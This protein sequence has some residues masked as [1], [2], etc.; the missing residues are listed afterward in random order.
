MKVKKLNPQYG[1]VSGRGRSENIIKHT[2]KFG[3]LFI[4][5]TLK[6]ISLFFRSS[7]RF[8]DT[9]LG[10]PNKR[11]LVKQS[12]I[13]LIWIHFLMNR[14]TSDD[15]ITLQQEGASTSSK[16]TYPSFFIYPF[17][18]YKTTITRSPMAHKTYSQEQFLVRFYRLSVSFNTPL[19]DNNNPNS[20]FNFLDNLNKS[21]IFVHFLRKNMPYL[22]TNMLFLHKYT[23]SFYSVDPTFFNLQILYKN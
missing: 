7:N 3:S 23:I 15:T 14:K 5:S 20:K 19:I 13:F 9:L 12:Y 16:L 1:S 6:D 18:N 10:K 11:I 17:R 22:G 21:F 4:P 8:G 2:L